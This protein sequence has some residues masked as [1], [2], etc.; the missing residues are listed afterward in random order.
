MFKD[1]FHK[2]TFVFFVENWADADLVVRGGVAGKSSKLFLFDLSGF[3]LF[4]VFVVIAKTVYRGGN[5]DQSDLVTAI[6]L[7]VFLL[8]L[9]GVFFFLLRLFDVKIPVIFD[10][11]D[12]IVF[13]ILLA[14]AVFATDRFFSGVLFRAIESGTCSILMQKCGTWLG[15][16]KALISACYVSIG[17]LV[18]LVN[19]IKKHASALRRKPNLRG[20]VILNCAVTV[21][22]AEIVGGVVLTV[23][24][25]TPT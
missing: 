14:I 2:E 4:Y 15:V 19:T 11:Y 9:G 12:K 20:P 21:I 13:I 18:L 3:V 24:V 7:Y 22:A 17:V 10:F 16:Q 1:L 8:Y 25:T 5:I 23:F 6:V